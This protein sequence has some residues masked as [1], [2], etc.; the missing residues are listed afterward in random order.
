MVRRFI[1]T[2]LLAASL[3]AS[4][5][6][7]SLGDDRVVAQN[8]SIKIVIEKVQG[9]YRETYFVRKDSAWKEI[10]TSGSLQRSEPALRLEG[11]SVPVA[12]T[13]LS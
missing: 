12:F 13:E 11:A 2:T 4:V 3:A 7:A 5:A 10:L 8:K 9:T 6:E 1:A